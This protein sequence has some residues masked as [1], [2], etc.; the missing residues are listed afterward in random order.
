MMMWGCTTMSAI[1]V[2]LKEVKDYV[3]GQQESFP[4]PLNRVLWAA[5]QS[6]SE[7]NFTL[8]R[9]EYF[10]QKALL[11]SEWQ[12]TAVALSFEAITPSLTKMTS[13]LKRGDATREFATERALFKHSREILEKNRSMR[14]ED[15]VKGMA[16]IHMSP[17]NHSPV[18]GYIRP[19]ENVAVLDKVNSWSKVDLMD[20]HTGYMRIVSPLAAKN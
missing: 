5:A 12:K 4:Y 19:G 2:T 13:K 16:A 1:P 8:N 3:V 15:L 10:N 20:G 7:T 11:Q 18:I 6:L 9:V 14:W 17:E